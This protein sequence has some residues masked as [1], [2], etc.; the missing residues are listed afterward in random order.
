MNYYFILFETDT[1][2]TCTKLYI[3]RTFH[4]I[5]DKVSCKIQYDYFFKNT[6]YYD[7]KLQIKNIIFENSEET[8]GGV[9]TGRALPLFV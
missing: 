7:E 3:L 8:G 1:Y 6:K 5:Y 4:S 2:T 9:S